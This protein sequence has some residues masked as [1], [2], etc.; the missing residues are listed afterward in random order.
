[1]STKP[2]LARGGS[3]LPRWF[4][5]NRVQGHTRLILSTTWYETPEFTQ[6]AAG[7][8]E[9]GA[10]AFTRHVKRGDEDPWWPTALPVDA[11]GTPHSSR[12]REINGVI[13]EPGENVAEEII[14]EAHAEGLKDSSSTTGTCPGRAAGVQRS[15]RPGRR[16]PASRRHP[17]PRPK[18]RSPPRGTWSFSTS[19][20]ARSRRRSP[21]GGTR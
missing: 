11:D 16:R 15:R 13:L 5:A 21:T 20:P 1:V 9:L 2:A 6:A 3:R 8:R 12:P 14:D 4:D 19:G 18:A 17:A 7:F 10:G